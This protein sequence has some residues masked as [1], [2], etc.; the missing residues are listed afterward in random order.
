LVILHGGDSRLLEVREAQCGMMVRYWKH[1]GEHE[2][3]V[4]LNPNGSITGG[5]FKGW[6]KVSG[7]NDE[8][9]QIER[10]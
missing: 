2:G 8:I 7:F 9:K 10:V 3:W 1:G 5:A 4:I 6:H